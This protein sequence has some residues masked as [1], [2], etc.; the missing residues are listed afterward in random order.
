[1]ARGRQ[2][3]R[4]ELHPPSGEARKKYLREWSARALYERREQFPPLSSVA[5]FGMET[6]LVVEIGPGTGEYLCALAEMRPEHLFLGIEASRRAVYHA[7]GLADEKGLN[8]IL[9]LRANVKLLYPLIPANCWRRVYLHFPDPVH[10]AKDEKLRIFDGEF[11]DVMAKSLLAGAEISVVSDKE[12]FFR[13]MLELVE[14]DTRFEKLH[15]E[16]YL[17]GFEP[18]AKS[19]F[20]RAWERKGV[21]PR[22]FLVRKKAG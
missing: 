22:R 11:L 17:E 16:R 10:K 13:E 12:D 9:F 7:V 20:Q 15:T 6:P 8:N 21:T 19:R 14:G 18:P 3:G 1:M 4:L 2:I 5:L